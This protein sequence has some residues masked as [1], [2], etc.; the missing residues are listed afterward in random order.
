MVRDFF[1]SLPIRKIMQFLG[2]IFIAGTVF[3][4]GGLYMKK[5]YALVGTAPFTIDDLPAG[6][7]FM[8]HPE[9][10]AEAERLEKIAMAHYATPEARERGG[11]VYGSYGY[12]IVAIEYEIPLASLG[13]RA[14]GD[15]L[16]GH[17]LA[18][19]EI[20]ALGKHISYDH[21]HIAISQHHHGETPEHEERESDEAERLIIHFMLISHEQEE[22][23]GLYCG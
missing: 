11:P 7:V 19:P 2:G 23:M 12:G 20:L 5:H 6:A 1:A 13:I 17:F 18:F 15:K 8:P 9:D 3:F 10:D 4:L 16:P 21:F 22:T 14:V